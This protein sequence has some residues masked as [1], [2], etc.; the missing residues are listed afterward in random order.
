MNK[1]F[2]IIASAFAVLTM[3]SCSPVKEESN[4]KTEIIEEHNEICL[5]ISSEYFEK[6]KY[7]VQV[8]EDNID[9]LPYSRI[10]IG[11]YCVA[12]FN[13]GEYSYVILPSCDKET[14]LLKLDSSTTLMGSLTEKKEIVTQGRI[15]DVNSDSTVFVSIIFD[16][17]EKDDLLFHI[18]TYLVYLDLDTMEIYC[19]S[20]NLNT[21]GDNASCWFS[22]SVKKSITENGKTNTYYSS[23]IFK[24]GYNCAKEYTESIKIKEYDKD[25]NLI[26][27]T[28]KDL[29]EIISSL[30]ENDCL[31]FETYDASPLCQYV[32]AE[33]IDKAGNIERIL[34]DKYSKNKTI[35]SFVEGDNTY[36]F[37]LLEDNISFK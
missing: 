6:T 36:G 24:I 18:Y 16:C 1:L 3:C 26:K 2:K 12:N 20:A 32:V 33:K 19:T 30:K 37:Y 31:H 27:E 29:A 15:F 9:S 4:T 10:K 35:K 11:E 14:G 25:N 23:Y 28:N 22:D 7:V 8:N 13:F 5:G 17:M 34:V 21:I